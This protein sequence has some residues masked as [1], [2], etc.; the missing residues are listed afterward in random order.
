[1]LRQAFLNFN[2]TDLIIFGFILFMLTFLG[3]FVW[4]FLIQEKS[5]YKDLSQLPLFNGDEK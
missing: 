3:A 4:T 1:M 5:F 2:Q